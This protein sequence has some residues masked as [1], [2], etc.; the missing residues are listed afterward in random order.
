[1]AK[2]WVTDPQKH[3]I[4]GAYADARRQKCLFCRTAAQQEGG[5]KRPAEAI[6]DG[7]PVKQT[8]RAAR[9]KL[10]WNE[11]LQ[12]PLKDVIPYI[13]SILLKYR[14]SGDILQCFPGYMITTG[15]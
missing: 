12:M 7:R 3:G 13:E 4:P 6:V 2:E 8:K 9:T 14:V 10:Q 5:V 15:S 1:M 11:T